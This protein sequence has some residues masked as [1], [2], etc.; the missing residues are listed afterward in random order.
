LYLLIKNNK[1][2]VFLVMTSHIHP[3]CCGAALY[4]TEEVVP[5]SEFKSLQTQLR[6]GYL[7]Y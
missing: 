1:K 7:E 5:A 3:L 6:H 2:R 4:A